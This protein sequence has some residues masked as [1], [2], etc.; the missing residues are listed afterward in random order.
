MDIQGFEKFLDEKKKQY[1]DGI[2]KALTDCGEHAISHVQVVAIPQAQPYPPVLFGNYRRSWKVLKRTEKSIEV[3]SDIPYAGVIEYGSRPH[4]PPMDAM[5]LWSMRKFGL[6]AK[7]AKQ[8]AFA[9][10][11]A[12]ANKGTKPRYIN[13]GSQP[14]F[15]KILNQSVREFVA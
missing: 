13:K 9:V 12:I 8:T 14:A 3:G 1:Q 2:K 11:R 15:Q 10:S 4:F 7:A 6:D 5:I